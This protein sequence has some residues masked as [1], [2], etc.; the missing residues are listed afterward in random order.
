MSLQQAGEFT[1]AAAANPGLMAKIIQ[2][3]ADKS[4][5]EAALAV[6]QLGKTE[7]F[8]FT[9]EEATETRDAFLA[10]NAGTEELSDDALT[11]VAGGITTLQTNYIVAGS[12]ILGGQ[13]VTGGSIIGTGIGTGI[14]TALNGGSASQSLGSG[15][16][17]AAQAQNDIG[18]QIRSFF[19]GW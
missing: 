13:A 17:A 5:A 3:T 4:P 14:T 18:A 16:I 9:A 15:A 11:A 7:G 8:E 12:G 19:S 10:A 6:S 2:L 1:V